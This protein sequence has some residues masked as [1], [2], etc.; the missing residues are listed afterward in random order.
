MQIYI[1]KKDRVIMIEK[2]FHRIAIA[3]R[4][5]SFKMNQRTTQYKKL[6]DSD[7]FSNYK[8]Y[9]SVHLYSPRID[10]YTGM[11]LVR[12]LNN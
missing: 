4:N 6:N 10:S 9:Y 5:Q 11:I 1:L 12:K 2:A 3:L 7:I 8:M